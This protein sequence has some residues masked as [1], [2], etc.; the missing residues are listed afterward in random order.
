MMDNLR[1]RNVLI[2]NAC[3]MCLRVEESVD[4]LL[5]GYEVAKEMWYAF[6]NL[7]DCHSVLPNSLFELLLA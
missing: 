2:V 7:F 5:L 6:L 4:H 1:R 3:P